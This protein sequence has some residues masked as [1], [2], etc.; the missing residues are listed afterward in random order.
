ML[1]ETVSVEGKLDV[2]LF[3]ETL[4]CQSCGEVCG[5]PLSYCR[6][7]HL[8]CSACRTSSNRTC[9]ICKQAVGTETPFNGLDKL[10][11]LIALPCRYS[12]AGCPAVLFFN[13]RTEHEKNVCRY[14]PVPCQYSS[15]GCSEILPFKVSRVWVLKK[16]LWPLI[17]IEDIALH[18]KHCIYR[19][20]APK[21]E[22]DIKSPAKRKTS[23]KPL[24]TGKGTIDSPEIKIEYCDNITLDWSY[25]LRTPASSE[26]AP[27]I[28]GNKLSF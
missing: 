6:K 13:M 20:T 27:P 15:R 23:S 25:P 14:R 3:L 21:L 22:P 8:Y 17:L 5:P 7:G 16:D 9:R 4:S 26:V 1:G 28:P 19:L 12:S 10:V 11:S 2:K 18:E 24:K